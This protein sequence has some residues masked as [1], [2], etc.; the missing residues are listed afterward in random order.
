M[1]HISYL[2]DLKI[3]AVYILFGIKKKNLDVTI[4]NHQSVFLKFKFTLEKRQF[5]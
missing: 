1:I 5:K 2:L 4:T 3:K